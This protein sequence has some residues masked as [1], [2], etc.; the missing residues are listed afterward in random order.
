MKKKLRTL[1]EKDFDI[2]ES[3]VA[4]IGLGL[5]ALTTI[6]KGETIGPYSGKILTEEQACSEPY[7]SSSY[8]LWVCNNY[9]IMGE[10]GESCY[11]RYINHS[12]HPNSRFVVSTRWK[13]ARLEALKRIRPNEEVFVDYGPYYWEAI[14]IKKK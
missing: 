14:G 2:R 10:G 12:D 11:T 3:S 6:C 1:N 9:Y 8:I 5:F 4:G 13:T 7:V